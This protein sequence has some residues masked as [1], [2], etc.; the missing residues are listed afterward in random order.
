MTMTGQALLKAGY[1]KF[2]P[3]KMMFEYAEAAF[4]KKIYDDNG[5]LMFFINVGLYD[6]AKHGDQFRHL[7][8]AYETDVLF[9]MGD[10]EN[11]IPVR[12]QRGEFNSVEEME[13]FYV[14]MFVSMGF[15]HDPHND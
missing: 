7:P 3:S 6:L 11:S 10:P 13:K 5:V 2:A 1:R 12:V 15:I 9:Y 4:Q 8:V 14:D